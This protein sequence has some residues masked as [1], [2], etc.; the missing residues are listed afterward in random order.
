MDILKKKNAERRSKLLVVARMDVKGTTG[1]P[2]KGWNDEIE[3]DLKIMKIRNWHRVARDRK[4]YKE[5]KL[6]YEVH[7]GE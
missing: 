2:R 4:V 6:E 1:K 7:N 5:I 3:L